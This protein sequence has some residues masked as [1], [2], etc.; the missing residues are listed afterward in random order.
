MWIEGWEGKKKYLGPK[1]KNL[2]YGSGTPLDR[3]V[4][5]RD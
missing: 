2:V 5:I 4:Y 1:E 3:E